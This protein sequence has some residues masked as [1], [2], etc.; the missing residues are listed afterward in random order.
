MT[1]IW[2]VEGTDIPRNQI[3]AKNFL[4]CSNSALGNGQSH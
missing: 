3:W 4:T 1:W 2:G